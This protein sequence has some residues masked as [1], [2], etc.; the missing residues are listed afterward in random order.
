MRNPVGSF[1]GERYNSYMES[2]WSDSRRSLQTHKGDQDHRLPFDHDYDRLLFSTPVRRLADKTQVFPLDKSDAVR[3]RLTHSH[4]VSNL[5]RSMGNR[6]IHEGFEFPDLSEPRAVPAILATIGLA[7]D[8]GNPPF[9]HQGE[10][11]IGNWFSDK[12]VFGSEKNVEQFVPLH[13]QPEFTE[14]EGNAQAFRILTKLQV[15]LGGH[16]L[17][18]T[19]ATLASL[20]KYP[21]SCDQR[22]KGDAATKKYGYFESEQEIVAWVRG[23]TDLQSGK[24]HPL[25]WLM[26]AA[27]DIAY[28]VL[29]IED[30]MHKGIVSPDDVRSL[31]DHHLGDDYSTDK[32]FI[33]RKFADAR[34]LGFSISE[35]REIMSSYLR[36]VFISRLINQ[37]IHAFVSNKSEIFSYS[38]KRP[39]LDQSE[40]LKTL[41][42]IAYEHVFVSADVRKIEADGFAIIGGLM[43]FYWHAISHREVFED[44][45][46]RRRD[47][48]SAYG[49]SKLSDNYFQR[50]KNGPCPD[51]NG[52][53]LSMRYKEL[54]LLTD[55]VSGMTDGF[56][57]AEYDALISDGFLKR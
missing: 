2:L 5:A 50:A 31:I 15:A 12:K 35:T 13:L 47:A 14:F 16:G 37:A 36:T 10:A 39:L 52:A 33:G 54:R 9:G 38:H 7:H 43:D 49:L 51:R 6:L 25:T 4:E 28:A 30:A 1:E 3:T 44:I 8:L 34:G 42:Q 41:K 26:E 48:R 18:F 19:A 27:D 32:D 29:D 23:E 11:A 17:D 22:S 20:M 53:E 57:K 45:N 24:R 46:S 55:M 21:V 56:A 40:L